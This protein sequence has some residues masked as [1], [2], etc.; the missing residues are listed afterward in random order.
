MVPMNKRC[1]TEQDV[2]QDGR[3]GFVI[4]L[5]SCVGH[6]RHY[7]KHLPFCFQ[8]RTLY[9]IRYSPAVIGNTFG[10]A[11]T[12]YS[13]FSCQELPL[14]SHTTRR[15]VHCFST[16]R[17]SVTGSYKIRHGFAMPSLLAC[18]LVLYNRW[19]YTTVHRS[20]PAQTSENITF[21]SASMLHGFLSY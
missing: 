4:P 21:G 3:S 13:Y 17:T 18:M 5:W 12:I 7:G 1:R 16:S 2:G 6:E 15:N 8:H 10:N 11:K 14:N 9:S 20:T 19:L